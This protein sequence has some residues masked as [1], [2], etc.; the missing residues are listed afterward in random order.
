MLLPSG[1]DMVRRACCTGPRPVTG[2]F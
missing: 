1:P 2:T